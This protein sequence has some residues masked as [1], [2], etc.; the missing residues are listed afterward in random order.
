MPTFTYT[1]KTAAGATQKGTIEARDKEAAFASLRAQHLHPVI[2]K[3][4]RKGMN[5]SMNITL[6]GSS[7]I[8]TK[9]LVIFTRQFATMV[10]AGVPLLRSLNTMRDQTESVALKGILEE[11]SSDVQGGTSLSDALA[12]HP[13]AFS[14]VYVNMVRAGE[15]GGILD[16]IMNRLANQ[17]EKDSAIVSKLRGAMI[18]PSVICLV[19]LGA[20]GFLMVAIIP[21]ITSILTQN[22]G[23]LP[24]QTKLLIDISSFLIHDWF[25]LIGAIIALVVGFKLIS[26]NP[27][28]KLALHKLQLKLPIFGTVITKVNIARFA[29]TFSSL[30]GAGVTVIESLTVTAD[31]L[32]NLVIRNAIMQAVDEIKAGHSIADSLSNDAASKVLPKILVQMAAVGE[33]T[34][35]MDTVLTKVADF[36]EEEVDVVIDSISAIIEPVL[37]VFLGGVVALIA[38]SVIGPLTSLESSVGN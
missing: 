33:E 1:A 17:V 4:V 13:K 2:V 26:R 7:G 16:Q 27:K 31:S 10:N 25:I 22:G 5:M 20:V 8:K 9:D 28:G 15:S 29:R 38:A 35:Q 12:K 30:M 11:V 14:A 23:K 34:G 3:P 18:Y 24:I 32:N 19:A 36:Y 21:K 6:P 37:I